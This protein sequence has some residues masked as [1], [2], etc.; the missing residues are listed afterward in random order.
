[1]TVEKK[2]AVREGRTMD[3]V[4]NQQETARELVS[5]GQQRGYD[6]E[7]L[8]KHSAFQ[9]GKR[10]IFI[11]RKRA[12]LPGT[13]R[14][15]EPEGILK[16]NMQGAISKLPDA[17]RHSASAFHG[18]WHEAGTFQSVEQ[19]VELVKAWLL[20]AK[21]VDDLPQRQVRSNGIG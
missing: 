20:D 11:W 2:V 3:M 17:Y 12:E 7:S 8:C 6:L 21:E 10:C 14:P 18:G 15:E 13:G 16:Y 19:A 5:H 9:R 4:E 1:M